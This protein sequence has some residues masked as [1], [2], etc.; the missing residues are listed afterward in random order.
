MIPVYQ[1]GLWCPEEL[2]GKITKAKKAW[3]KN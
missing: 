1:E 2:P 3:K